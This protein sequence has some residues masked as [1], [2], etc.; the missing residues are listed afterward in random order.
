M[1]TQSGVLPWEIP[2]TK[3]FG[4]LQSMGLQRV[5]YDLATKQQ[6]DHTG[7]IWVVSGLLHAVLPRIAL[8]TYRFVH[9]EVYLWD[10]PPK[11]KFL[12]QRLYAFGNGIAFHKDSAS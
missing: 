10:K 3:E 9:M 2:W 7:E 12:R 11:V 1:A 5:G 4:A 8:C 6:T